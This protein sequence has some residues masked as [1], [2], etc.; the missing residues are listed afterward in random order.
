M[1]GNTVCVKHQHEKI[2]FF[3]DFTK[4]TGKHFKFHFLSTQV[5]E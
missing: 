3:F 4:K 2:S 1:S 5:L